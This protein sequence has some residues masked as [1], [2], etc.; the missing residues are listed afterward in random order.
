MKINS[1]SLDSRIIKLV[2]NFL[3]I[4]VLTALLGIVYAGGLY[5]TRQQGMLA[6]EQKSLVIEKLL[7]T[8]R[9]N[10][11]VQTAGMESSARVRELLGVQLS[12]DIVLL[13][14]MRSS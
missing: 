11:L 9:V 4:L 7:S 13:D 14:S 3:G 1:H 10:C 2:K 5:E 12:S 6:N 8:A